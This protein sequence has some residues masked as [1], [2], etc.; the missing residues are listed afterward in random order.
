MNY[1]EFLQTE[2]D[3]LIDIE[4]E[5]NKNLSKY[6]ELSCNASRKYKYKYNEDILRN[7]FSIDIDKILNN[8]LYNRYVD[9]TQVFS[10]YKNDDITRRALHVQ[11]VARIAH[12]IG[13]WLNLNLDLIHAIALGHDI[14]HTPFG[15][16][17]EDFLNELYF[18]NTGRHFRHNLHS[19]RVLKTITNSNLTLQVYDGILAHC[20]ESISQKYEPNTRI[21]FNEFENIFENCYHD[22]NIIKNLRAFTLEGC[23]VRISDVL[24]YIGKDRQDASKAD[25]IKMYSYETNV[26]NSEFLS[27]A[28]A[29]IIKNSLD[30]PYLSMSDNMLL[31]MEK[32]KQENYEIIY[33]NEDVISIYYE[34]IKPMM[35]KIYKTMLYD[36][37]KHNFDSPIFRH[38][39]NHPI[40]GNY[41]RNKDNRK[42]VI[43][44][45]EVVTD[46][47]A[48]MTDDYFIDLYDFLFGKDEYSRKIKYI[49]YFYDYEKHK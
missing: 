28:I 10:F 32:Y 35:E 36:Y 31:E 18:E 27:E 45:N 20:G 37:N 47:I 9:K 25:L 23:V 21:D 40:L 15:H 1:D 34:A 43:E 17:G 13:Y 26:N 19:V 24:A 44:G 6:A 11:L 33:N 49:S 48:S 12:C 16:K 3:K 22:D 41:C 2:K 30:K 7:P 14:G 38:H 4:K 5:H 39:I 46:Y 8:A 42:L 29:D